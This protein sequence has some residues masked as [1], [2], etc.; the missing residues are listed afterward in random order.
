LADAPLSL[1]AIEIKHDQMMQLKLTAVTRRVRPC[2]RGMVQTL[3][4]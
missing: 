3:I 4:M 1:K 2:S